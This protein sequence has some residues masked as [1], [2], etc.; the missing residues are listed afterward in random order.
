M[1]EPPNEMLWEALDIPHDLLDV[2]LL[3]QFGLLP[4]LGEAVGRVPERRRIE[5]F[6]IVTAH[7]PGVV[8]EGIDGGHLT[9]DP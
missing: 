2:L 9:E 8:G 5:T 7:F 3:L 1:F 6:V 4:S